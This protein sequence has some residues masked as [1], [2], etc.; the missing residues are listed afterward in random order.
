[1]VLVVTGC[2]YIVTRRGRG[3]GGCSIYFVLAYLYHYETY[4]ARREVEV[5]SF[6]FS[7]CICIYGV[8][9]TST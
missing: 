8:T 9:H 7:I 2:I 4:C 3:F 6:Y 5:V 1:M